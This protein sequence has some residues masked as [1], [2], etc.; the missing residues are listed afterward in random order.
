MPLR[1]AVVENEMMF[2]FLR[3]NNK[4]DEIVYCSKMNNGIIEPFN[5]SDLDILSSFDIILIEGDIVKVE[6][7]RIMINIFAREAKKDIVISRYH[8]N[9]HF[10]PFGYYQTILVNESFYN[11]K[12]IPCENPE[13][14]AYESAILA[15]EDLKHSR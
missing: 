7:A 4:V 9:S 10:D 5:V 8:H 13:Y 2:N 14:L 6:K 12:E 1:I 11:V 15:Y 3:N